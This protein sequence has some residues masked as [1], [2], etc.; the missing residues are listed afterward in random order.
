MAPTSTYMP[1]R[2]GEHHHHR[3]DTAAWIRVLWFFQAG[4]ALLRICF[5]AVTLVVALLLCS[6]LNAPAL[7]FVGIIL[8]FT[9]LIISP[10]LLHAPNLD[11]DRMFGFDILLA[12]FI[13]RQ[14]WKQLFH[15]VD[16]RTTLRREVYKAVI[17]TWLFVSFASLPKDV[18]PATELD[19][20]QRAV[21]ELFI[22]NI[23]VGQLLVTVVIVGIFFPPL[24]V[25]F[26][27]RNAEKEGTNEGRGEIEL[28]D[29]EIQLLGR[30][31]V[32]TLD[33]LAE[34]DEENGRAKFKV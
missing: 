4:V 19:E 8:Y 29:H 13:L 22:N 17:A 34:E 2:S 12:S 23:W 9:H 32:D 1:L 25:A 28:E 33:G 3:K 11:R 18:K 30:T 6:M 10:P 15:I 20:Q 7:V 16:K 5:V 21:F 26:R 14:V 24:W 31:S 27:E